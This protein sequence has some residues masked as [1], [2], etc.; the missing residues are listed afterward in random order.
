MQLIRVI[1][2]N[3]V[4]YIIKLSITGNIKKSGHMTNN[5]VQIYKM[6]KS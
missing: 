4:T 3:L 1:F 5:P 2:Q 6:Q